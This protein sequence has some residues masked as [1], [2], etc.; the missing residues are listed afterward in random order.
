M[1]SLKN[2]SKGNEIKKSTI[3]IYSKK[4]AAP[5]DAGIMERAIAAMEIAIQLSDKE[6]GLRI[7][8]GHLIKALEKKQA[9]ADE[10]SAKHKRKKPIKLSAVVTATRRE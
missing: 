2:F 9:K 7:R 3:E 4:L 6:D 10:K 5:K 1:Y 8:K